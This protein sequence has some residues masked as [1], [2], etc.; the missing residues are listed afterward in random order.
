ME[1]DEHSCRILIPKCETT[2]HYV[3][4]CKPLTPKRR[5]FFVEL[6]LISKTTTSISFVFS[7]H[8]KRFV[9]SSDEQTEV[10]IGIASAEHELNEA[11]GLDRDTV[12]YNSLTGQLFS[13]RKDTGNMRGHRCRMGDQMG[14]EIE[15]FGKEMSVVLFTKNFRPVGTRYLTLKDA[16]QFFPTILIESNGEPVEILVHW[17]TRV[18][19]PTSFNLV[20]RFSKFELKTTKI[21]V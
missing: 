8:H 4:F 3:Q 16:K 10:I 21:F 1:I 15:A 18:S 11:P 19:L 14:V 5:Y 17:Q 2:V 12:G 6:E 20:R 9:S 13:N 7:F